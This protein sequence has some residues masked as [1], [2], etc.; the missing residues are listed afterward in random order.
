MNACGLVVPEQ[1]SERSSVILIPQRRFIKP[2]RASDHVPKHC[3]SETVADYWIEGLELPRGEYD[4]FSGINGC[5][6][7]LVVRRAPHLNH[8]TFAERPVMR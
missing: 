2:N 7:H 8:A 6:I 3:G 5:T 4:V 1:L